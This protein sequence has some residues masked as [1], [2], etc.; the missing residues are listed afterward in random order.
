MKMVYLIGVAGGTSSGKT[1]TCDI[2]REQMKDEVTI[3]SMDNFYLENLP[4]QSKNLTELSQSKN[5]INYDHP[6]SFDTPLILKTLSNIKSGQ[7]EIEIPNYCFITGKRL[8]FNV[9]KINECVIFEGILTLYDEKIRNLFDLKIFVDTPSDIRLIRRIQRDILERQRSL[10]NIL[11]QYEESVI[12]SHDQ[13]IEP[14]KK[15]ADLIIPRGKDNTIAINM[16]VSFILN[17]RGK[18]IQESEKYSAQLNQKIQIFSSA[19]SEEQIFEVSN[20]QEFMDLKYIGPS[21]QSG[22]SI[23]KLTGNIKTKPTRTSIQIGPDKHIEDEWGQYINHSCYPSVKIIDGNLVAIK[24]LELETSITFDYNQ[25]ED[26]MSDPFLC[27]CCN[28]LIGGKL[29]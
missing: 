10:E 29:V 15:Y 13:F 26:N 24:E 19:E 17:N 4:N 27:H 7:S 25:N 6:N 21:V 8:N 16:L 18:N 11:R 14:T 5:Q 2:I 9:I 12:P 23:Y 22:T 28:K 20:I 1:S 3:I